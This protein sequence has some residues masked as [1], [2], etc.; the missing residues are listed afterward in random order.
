[1]VY[2]YGRALS[3]PYILAHTSI[4]A[5]PESHLTSPVHSGRIR[6]PIAEYGSKVRMGH[7]C[8][9]H[10]ARGALRKTKPTKKDRHKKKQN[11]N[12]K[13]NC[14][15]LNKARTRTKKKLSLCDAHAPARP[16]KTWQ[17]FSR[18]LSALGGPGA[19]RGRQT[20]KSQICGLRSRLETPDRKN[21]SDRKPQIQNIRF[22]VCGLRLER[23]KLTTAPFTPAPFFSFIL[24]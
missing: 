17:G 10:T 23:S 7:L 3:R 24:C 6:P 15:D 22:A 9:A 13:K 4:A 16:T 14:T 8:G 18:P 2:I 19:A 5:I 12:R 20:T 21:M 1:M 11:N